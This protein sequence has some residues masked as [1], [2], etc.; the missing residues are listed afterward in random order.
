MRKNVEGLIW[1]KKLDLKD[2]YRQNWK[3]RIKRKVMRNSPRKQI[4]KLKHKNPNN[5]VETTTAVFVPPSEGGK[6]S[7]QITELEDNHTNETGWRMKIVES[8]GIPIAQLLKPVF[9]MKNGC[10]LGSLGKN[11]S[12]IT[13]HNFQFTAP[14]PGEKIT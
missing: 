1:Y 14:E 13:R 11:D 12:I 10:S 2:D 4:M 8:S 6:L 3:L 7:K 9:P 5:F